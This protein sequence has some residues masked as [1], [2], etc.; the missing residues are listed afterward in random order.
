M[1]DY[2]G[3]HF[4]SDSAYRNADGLANSDALMI[5]DNPS[6]FVWSKSAPKDE[7]KSHTTDLGTALHCRILEPE[8]YEDLI[9]I[10]SVKGR[11]TDKFSKEVEENKCK[12]VLTKD[13]NDQI[14][15]M[16]KSVYSHPA[17]KSLL[18]LKGDC[19]SSVFVVDNEYGVKIKCRPDKDCVLSSGIIVDVKTTASLDDWRSD[20]EWVNPLFKFSY[21][22]QASFYTDALEQHHKKDIDS[23]VFLVIQKNVELGRY[24]VGVFQISKHELIEL[25]FWSSHRD[26]ISEYKRCVDSDDWIH[27]EPFRFKVDSD[28]FSDDIEI[29]FEGESNA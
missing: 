26:N 20:K 10:S 28:D 9:F 11:N 4:I 13:E 15:L 18:D 17:A 24:P 29:T 12:L 19:E 23:F 16:A 27:I 21:G 6:D 7:R 8:R 14:E 2:L 22:H 3:K 1:S 25:G 5:S